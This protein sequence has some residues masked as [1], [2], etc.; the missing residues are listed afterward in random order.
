M[1]LVREARISSFY[2]VELLELNREK[3]REHPWKT[4]EIIF[5]RD[6]KL[7]NFENLETLAFHFLNF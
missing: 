1:F 4:W 3:F 6:L 5:R 7:K 2:L